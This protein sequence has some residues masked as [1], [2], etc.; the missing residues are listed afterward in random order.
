MARILIVLTSHH[1]LGDTG[2]ATGY[3]YEEL[4]APYYAFVDAG[5]TVEIASIAGGAPKADPAS[6]DADEAKRPSDVR[7]L[8]ADEA[9]MDALSRTIAIADVDPSGYDAVFLPG[10]HGTMWDFP[11]NAALARAVSTIH[12]AGGIVGSVC[13]GP[14]GFVGATRPDGRPLVE[15]VRINGFTDEEEAKVGLVDTVPFLLESRLV[16]LGARFEKGG[17]FTSYAVRDGRIVTGQN[18]M[19]SERAAALMLEALAEVRAA[20]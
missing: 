14:A 19:S 1:T 20:A 2:K 17:P 11:D 8:L 18:P 9:A 5:H 10:G 16:A 7:R 12:A 15:G 4:A 13:H 6:L 3:Y